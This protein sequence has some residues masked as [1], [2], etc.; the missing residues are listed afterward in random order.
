MDDTKKFLKKIG[1]N[2]VSDGF[3]SDKRFGDGG[4]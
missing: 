1:I 2:E 3:K 4:Q